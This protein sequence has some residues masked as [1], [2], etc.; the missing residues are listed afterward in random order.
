MV[1]RENSGTGF[2]TELSVDS[3][4]AAPLGSQ[5]PLGHLATDLS[6]L[7]HG[8]G[9]VVF[10]TTGYVSLIEG[11]SYEED[12]SAIDFSQAAFTPLRPFS[13]S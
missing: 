13:S 12:T 11:Y 10:L 8:M 4:L 6:E 2:F 3:S 7:D 9:F 1:S 5:G